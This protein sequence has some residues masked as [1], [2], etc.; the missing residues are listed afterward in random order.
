MKVIQASTWPFKQQYEKN[1]NKEIDSF[2]VSRFGYEYLRELVGE[3][4]YQVI[5]P[6]ESW[7]TNFLKKIIGNE[8]KNLVLQIIVAKASKNT[9]IIY[10]PTDRHCLLLP[11]LRKLRI[12]KCPILMVSHFTYNRT[13]VESKIKKILITIERWLVYHWIDRI[14][15]ASEHILQL[16]KEDCSVPLRHQHFVGWGADLN[17]FSKKTDSIY[18]FPY[19]LSAGGA[20]RDY[21]TLIRAFKKINYNL[22][23]SCD[24][25]SVE[26]EINTPPHY[27]QYSYL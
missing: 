6:R 3:T 20:N 23:L 1:S 9:D 16:A 17:Y 19:F 15:F 4:G 5:A 22:V 7:I 27:Q 8:G 10:Y 26:S 24:P 18:S 11:I 12:C 21:A 14:V 13:C 2:S 25:K